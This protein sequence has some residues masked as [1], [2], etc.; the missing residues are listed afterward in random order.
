MTLLG[1]N[2]GYIRST[3][4]AL[5]LRV[6]DKY[7]ENYSEKGE[8]NLHYTTIKEEFERTKPVILLQ[9]VS[10]EQFGDGSQS[11]LAKMSGRTDLSPDITIDKAWKEASSVIS[12]FL[13]EHFVSKGKDTVDESNFVLM[14]EKRKRSRTVLKSAG[15]QTRDILGSYLE[16]IQEGKDTEFAKEMQLKLIK[17]SATDNTTNSDFSTEN[18][19]IDCVPYT[20]KQEFIYSDPSLPPL[21]P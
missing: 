21:P 2:D 14:E 7:L 6:I 5:E 13:F 1:E 4:G 16:N 8:Q 9:G 3:A 11:K 10:H 15:K 19:F 12:A 17:S 20:L 18:C